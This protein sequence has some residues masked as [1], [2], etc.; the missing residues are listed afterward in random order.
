MI[1]EGEGMDR[2]PLIEELCSGGFLGILGTRVDVPD[3]GLLF[4]VFCVARLN[5]PPFQELEQIF[6]KLL[7]MSR[8]TCQRLQIFAAVADKEEFYAESPNTNEPEV[9]EGVIRLLTASL[10]DPGQRT[11]TT[12][13]RLLLAMTATRK[14][15]QCLQETDI[16]ELFV[17]HFL[18]SAFVDFNYSCAIIKNTLKF[19]DKESGKELFKQA[20][21]V[22]SRL[23]QVY[24]YEVSAKGE[25]LHKLVRLVEAYPKCIQK[26]DVIQFSQRLAG[27]SPRIVAFSLELMQAVCE[28][29]EPADDRP[30]E[31]VLVAV[32]EALSSA[33]NQ[34]VKVV[35]TACKIVI[36]LTKDKPSWLATFFTET[37]FLEY[38][39][40]FLI[41]A[42][43]SD[44]QDVSPEKREENLKRV[45]DIENSASQLGEIARGLPARDDKT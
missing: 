38:L 36:A 8:F 32:V 1:W 43:E 31:E 17:K 27:S 41:K 10:G 13:F 11:V 33:G 3:P 12:A 34:H 39:D 6:R 37:G 15:V 28:Q 40:A 5:N 18:S 30:D 19:R 29:E 24:L 16:F 42:R 26:Q 25:V 45:R 14:G 35:R 9:I 7:A 21:Q 4:L 20:A 44:D 22:A 23:I 2:A